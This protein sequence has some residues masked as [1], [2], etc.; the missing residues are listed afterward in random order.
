MVLWGRHPLERYQPGGGDLGPAGDCSPACRAGRGLG[1]TLGWGDGILNLGTELGG[2][3]KK[4]IKYDA[5][6]CV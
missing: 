1:C 4:G 6:V 2:V 5:Q 3:G